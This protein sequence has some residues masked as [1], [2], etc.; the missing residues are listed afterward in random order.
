MSTNEQ[1][2][3]DLEAE[4][5]AETYRVLLGFHEAL[6]KSRRDFPALKNY[7]QYLVAGALLSADSVNLPIDI[8][9]LAAYTNMQ[10]SSLYKTLARMEQ[11]KLVELYTIAGDKKRKYVKS[12]KLLV[13]QYIE[14]LDHTKILME[15]ATTRLGSS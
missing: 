8:S 14:L 15:F 12:T 1:S 10:R 5:A 9:A 4:N 2:N 13:D 7:N 6:R 3:Q 11:E